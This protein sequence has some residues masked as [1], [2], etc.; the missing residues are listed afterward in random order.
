M[1]STPSATG[2]SRASQDR[3][4]VRIWKSP[5]RLR[6]PVTREP[7]NPSSRPAVQAAAD[8]HITTSPPLHQRHQPVAMKVVA[9][10]SGGKDSTFNM[11]ECVRLGHEIVAL[12]NLYPEP[13]PAPGSRDGADEEAEGGDE[14]D[15]LDSYMFQTV[16]HTVIGAYAACMGGVPLYRRA[17]QRGGSK[18]ARRRRTRQPPLLL[19]HA[20]CPKGAGGARAQCVAGSWGV[21]RRMVYER[22]DGDEVEDLYE[23]LLEVTRAQ[24]EVTAVSSGAVLSDYQRLRVEHVC[25]RLGLTSLAYMWQRPQQQLLRTMV[26]RGVDAIV[27]KVAAMGLQP[28]QLGRTIAEL[29]PRFCELEDKYGNHAAGEGGEYESL[30]LDCP[31]FSQRLVIDEVR[32]ARGAA[33]AAAAAAAT[34]GN[35][36]VPLEALPAAGAPVLCVVCWVVSRRLRRAPSPSC[37]SRC[38]P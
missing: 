26:E 31:L 19:L 33:A 4:A 12:A 7:V 20:T 22:T 11:M 34:G 15:E 23:L 5:C 18:G 21:E 28:A 16:G 1:I 13:P 6:E 29:A 32:G 17:I 36:E 8:H 30:T 24:P 35:G 9:L 37:G 10:I 14:A 38:A 2:D 27:V 25:D 3:C